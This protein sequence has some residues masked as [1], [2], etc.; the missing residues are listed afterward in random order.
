[1]RGIQ[2]TNREKKEVMLFSFWK[3]LGGE[4]YEL[5][6]CYHCSTRIH[7]G[8]WNECGNMWPYF[9]VKVLPR[10]I[11]RANIGVVLLAKEFHNHVYFCK[12]CK[13][14]IYAALSSLATTRLIN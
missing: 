13:A 3:V 14:I 7:T 4:N 12:G 6:L 5:A 1:M 8:L 2:G 10:A 11:S 9:D